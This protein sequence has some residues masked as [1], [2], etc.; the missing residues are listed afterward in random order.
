LNF[1]KEFN[2]DF[3]PTDPTFIHPNGHDCST[4]DYFLYSECLADKTSKTTRID[5]IASNVSDHYPISLALSVGLDT[6]VSAHTTGNP[7][8]RVNWTKVDLDL[9][10]AMVSD[11]VTV[12]E[13]NLKQNSAPKAVDL[14]L[15]AF[16][17]ALAKAAE[18]S[19]PAL[20]SNKKRI[21]RFRSKEIIAAERGNK[22]SLYKWKLAGKP[23][24][25]SHPTV[26]QIKASKA[27]LRSELRVNEAQKRFDMKVN[28]MNASDNDMAMFYQLVNRQRK[29]TSQINQLDVKGEI[30]SG[31]EIGNGWLKHFKDLATPAANNSVDHDY[32]QQTERDLHAIEYI[33]KNTSS[34]HSIVITRDNVLQAINSLNKG[35]AADV[36]NISVEHRMGANQ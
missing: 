24:S 6:L 17:D 22:R 27:E 36:Y 2:L 12:L 7:R 30:Y 18:V 25:P 5:G 10:Q 26:I 15:L 33:C 29:N 14:Q 13:T 32:I 23:R 4:I 35:K 8:L 16:S 21:K 19:S 1:I 3:C 28:S 31:D 20:L 9:Y 11:S 34:T